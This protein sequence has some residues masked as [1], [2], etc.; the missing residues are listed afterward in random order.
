MNGRLEH[1]LREILRERR[2]AAEG[3]DFRPAASCDVD[4]RLHHPISEDAMPSDVT[5]GRKSGPSETAPAPSPDARLRAA[6][7]A[8]GGTVVERPGGACIVVERFYP[9]DHQHGLWRIADAAG[10]CLGTA[11]ELSLLGG[12]PEPDDAD[13]RSLLFIDLETTGLA[14]GAGTYAFLVGCA[15]FERH[16][17][18]TRQFFLPGYKHERPLL[19]AVEALV[20]ASAGLV[21]Y[22]GKTFDVPVLETRFQF[23]RLPAPFAD[24]GHV[25]MLHPARRFWRGAAAGPGAWPE[26][27]S[28]RL[29]ILERTLFGVRRIGDVPGLEIPARYFGFMRT[30]DASPL[31]P[32]LE[33]NRLDLVSLALLT[34]RAVLMLADAPARCASARESLGAGRLLERAGRGA[35]AEQCYRDAADRAVYE[36]GADAPS[37]RADALRALAVCC[38]RDGRHEHA[39]DAWQAITRDRWAPPA[40]RREA[41][42]ALAIHFEHRSKNLAEARRFAQMSL[43]ERLGTRG[44]EG[45]RYRLARLDRKLARRAPARDE[46]GQPLP[47]G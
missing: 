27:D 44:M 38:R 35:T 46:P 37:I 5:A 14:G 31:E 30:G 12:R 36:R 11:P 42:E 1:R 39:I 10:P 40:L 28:C 23:N 7:D 3:P 47:L 24:I 32:V 6:A 21:S 16:G 34:A 20:R 29:S 33:H 18:R 43:A 9:A 25:D 22:N 15:E 2:N 13:A 19:A 41:L 4:A 45:G 8:L 26:G 17:F